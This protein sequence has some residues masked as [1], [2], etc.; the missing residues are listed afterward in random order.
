MALSAHPARRPVHPAYVRVLYGLATTRM[1]APVWPVQ[2]HYCRFPPRDGVG[3]RIRAE[4]LEYADL[5]T[6]DIAYLSV[7]GALSV[8]WRVSLVPQLSGRGDTTLVLEPCD[9]QVGLEALARDL[10]TIGEALP[11]RIRRLAQ[12]RL[13]CLRDPSA[14][15]GQ[16]ALSAREGEV[17]D[18]LLA[19]FGVASL[20]R[21]LFISPHTVRN[22]I[23]HICAKLDVAS[24]TE[25]RELFAAVH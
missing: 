9:A 25:L 19:G 4:L 21:Q 18:L 22:H 7:I 1:L 24:Q 8:A 13:C 17:L 12:A 5:I 20:A 11:A 15:P 16:C 23:K 10:R 3:V 2:D 6:H 14:S